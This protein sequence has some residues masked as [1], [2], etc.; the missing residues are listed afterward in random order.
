MDAA[1]G[2]RQEAIPNG[3][4]LMPGVSSEQLSNA[5]QAERV[6]KKSVLEACLLWRGMMD[7]RAMAKRTRAT[8]STVRGRLVRKGLW[9]GKAV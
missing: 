8:Y 3:M 2:E 4:K 1:G 9:P 5:F 7:I 6:G